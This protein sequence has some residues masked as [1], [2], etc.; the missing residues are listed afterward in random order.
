M[1]VGMV[2]ALFG[3][4]TALLLSGCG[5]G[6][7]Q[8]TQE[9]W[10]NPQFGLS[11]SYPSNWVY[12]DTWMHGADL[13]RSGEIVLFHRP[14]EM[15]TGE[16]RDRPPL[17]RL[18]WTP[19]TAAPAGSVP[20]ATGGVD[21]PMQQV[22]GPMGVPLNVQDTGITSGWVEMGARDIKE[23]QYIWE[24]NIPAREATAVA[25]TRSAFSATYSGQLAGQDLRVR[26]IWLEFSTGRLEIVAVAP[27]GSD[28]MAAA[29]QIAESIRYQ[30]PR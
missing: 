3:I 20:D 8:V 10:A 13:R 21:I 4:W 2:F 14:V 25:P 30:A 1:K 29:S 27:E 24:G 28:D 22:E 17:V 23:N 7:E 19:K 12:K 9:S 15:G 26:E 6:E 18:T 16:V 11:A 5:K